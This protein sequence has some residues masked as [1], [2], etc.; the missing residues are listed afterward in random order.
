MRVIFTS[1]G[2]YIN[3]TR[4][5]R[6]IGGVLGNRLLGSCVHSEAAWGREPHGKSGR[7]SGLPARRANTRLSACGF[8]DPNLVRRAGAATSPPHQRSGLR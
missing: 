3:S 5:R 2:L 1:T 7:V 6:V 8:R 4:M